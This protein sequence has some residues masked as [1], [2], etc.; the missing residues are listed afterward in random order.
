MSIIGLSALTFVC[1]VV[2]AV[3]PSDDPWLLRWSGRYFLG[4][5]LPVLCVVAAQAVLVLL[6]PLSANRDRYVA[7]GCLVSGG[8][9]LVLGVEVL[10]LYELPLMAAFLGLMAFPLAGYR[11]FRR[12]QWLTSYLA[13][14]LVCLVLFVPEA[15][16]LVVAGRAPGD[17]GLPRWGD[18]ATFRHLF[19][20]AEPFISAGGRLQPNLDLEVFTD[21]PGRL[22]Y[23]LKTNSD[24]FRNDHEIP[25]AKEPGE[26]RI[27]SLGDSFSVGYGIDQERFLGP[28][29]ESRW[30]QE[31]S[32]RS[33]RK[34]RSRPIPSGW[35]NR[36]KGSAMPN[37]NSPS[38]STP[39]RVPHGSRSRAACRNIRSR[40]WTG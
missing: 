5:V 21:V 1:I 26:L 39:E 20:E 40:G 15:A 30:R 4:A 13:L 6:P 38:T 18:Q 3:H 7:L 2:F 10:P 29:L 36:S 37:C 22:A 14:I 34:A 16:R 24:G 12:D 27:L 31:R 35:L 23:H 28:L 17:Y 25:P 33:T 32:S 8:L 19:P 11:A 9:V